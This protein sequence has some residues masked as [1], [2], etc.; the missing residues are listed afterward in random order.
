MVMGLPQVGALQVI[1]IG[2]VPAPPPPGGTVGAGVDDGPPGM[3]VGVE[4]G[5]V[6]V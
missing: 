2:P 6:V 1:L 5:G 4:S 3:G